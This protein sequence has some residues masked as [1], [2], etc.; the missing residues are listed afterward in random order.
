M[1]WRTEFYR[2]FNLFHKKNERRSAQLTEYRSF[3][4]YIQIKTR[5]AASFKMLTL[6][7]AFEKTAQGSYFFFLSSHEKRSN[8]LPSGNGRRFLATS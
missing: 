2:L 1:L 3:F 8:D 7:F 6:V 5:E 4:V